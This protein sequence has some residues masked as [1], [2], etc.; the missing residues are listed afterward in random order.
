[1][2]PILVVDRSWWAAGVVSLLWVAV[3]TC[4]WR[5]RPRDDG[6]LIIEVTTDG[7]RSQDDQEPVPW[8]A[9][10]WVGFRVTGASLH[11]SSRTCVVLQLEDGPQVEHPVDLRRDEVR[12][13]IRRLAPQ[14][15]IYTGPW[16]D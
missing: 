12:S 16:P 8:T 3:G 7:I 13:A 2:L 4:V 11:R 10:A 5:F 9:V 14:V 1:M 6:K 15:R